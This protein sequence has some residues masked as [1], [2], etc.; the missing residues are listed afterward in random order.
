MKFI[1]EDDLRTIYRDKPFTSFDIEPDS[2]LTPGARQFLQD[3]QINVFADGT[4]MHVG[5]G[6][7]AG[8]EPSSGSPD[9]L[10]NKRL[11]AALK[12]ADALFLLTA[13]ELIEKDVCLA[14]EVLDLGQKFDE[15]K[16][17]DAEG[18][19]FEPLPC[20][21]CS[22]MNDS[23]FSSDLGECFEITSFHIQ[24]DKGREILL[25]HRLRCALYEVQVVVMETHCTNKC[26][27]E[28]LNQIINRLGQMI[29]TAFGGNGCQRND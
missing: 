9:L 18:K 16:Q 20:K 14:Q 17:M 22:C 26:I 1:T 4:A 28:R 5:D 10:R 25:L 12:S 15:I 23:N 7:I 8:K 3:R 24:A 21:T 29:C 13:S 19:M 2:R 11:F 27:T 6:V